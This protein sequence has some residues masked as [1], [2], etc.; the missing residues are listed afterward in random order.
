MRAP[1]IFPPCNRRLLAHR[2]LVRTAC[3]LSLSLHTHK[4]TKRDIC[5]LRL[6]VDASAGG[7]STLERGPRRAQRRPDDRAKRLRIDRVMTARIDWANRRTTI[8][9]AKS[10]SGDSGQVLSL[11]RERSGTRPALHSTPDD[12]ADP[13]L[14]LDANRRLARAGRPAW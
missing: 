4:R 7:E 5:S 9:R 2:R 10:L 12:R 1:N 3:R 11:R 13:R 6:V 14:L 8:G